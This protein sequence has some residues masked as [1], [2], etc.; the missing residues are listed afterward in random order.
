M[1]ELLVC[2]T[3]SGRAEP[4]TIRGFTSR[5]GQHPD[6]WIAVLGCL[7]HDRPVDFSLD[8]VPFVVAPFDPYKVG[9]RYAELR[10]DAVPVADLRSPVIDHQPTLAIAHKPCRWRV[11]AEWEPGITGTAII[12]AETAETAKMHAVVGFERYRH[13]FHETA[14]QD[15]KRLNVAP[16]WRPTREGMRVSHVEPAE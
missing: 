2:R 3:F 15:L 13:D 10:G 4:T 6:T 14:E 16:D 8:F 1:S 7:V 9:W 5:F 12:E 11:Y